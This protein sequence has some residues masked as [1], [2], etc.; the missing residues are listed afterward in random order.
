ME[1]SRF[2]LL[3]V[4][5][6]VLGPKDYTKWNWDAI[7]ELN[8]SSFLNPQRFDELVRATK[9]ASRLIHF[10]K[11]SSKQFSELKQDQDSLKIVR[12]CCALMRNL[13]STSAGYRFIQESKIISEINE[14]LA[15]LGD[16]SNFEVDAVFSKEGIEN[17]MGKE[18]FT[19]LG[20]IQKLPEGEKIFE[21]NNLWTTYYTL[22]ELK[23]KDYLVKCL[24][25]A[26]NFEW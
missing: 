14:R 8:K 20:E 16:P 2:K 5:S 6:E 24:I 17:M 7:E 3:L 10:L 18:Y 22:I 19:I 1:E 11:P 13:A 15:K 25:A 12:S 4:E 9:Y 23:G 21:E 26:G